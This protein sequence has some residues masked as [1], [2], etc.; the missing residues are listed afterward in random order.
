M[1]LDLDPMP[2]DE[3]QA[4]IAKLYALP[5]SIIQHARQALVYTPPK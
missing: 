1:Q 4:L 2:G 5:Q 3:L